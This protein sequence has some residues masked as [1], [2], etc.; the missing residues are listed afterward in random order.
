MKGIVWKNVD[1]C[2]HCSGICD[3]GTHKTIFGK[4]FNNVCRTAFRFDI[5]SAEAAESAK[6]L[7]ELRKNDIEAANRYAPKEG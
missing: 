1:F 7:V 2:G 6:R 5:P 4:E 3:G